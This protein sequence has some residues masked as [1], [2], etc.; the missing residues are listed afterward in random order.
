LAENYIG[1][2]ALT[3]G[4]IAYQDFFVRDQAH[5][6]SQIGRDCQAP[7]VMQARA[8][9]CGS[10]N[11]AF[12]KSQ[13]HRLFCDATALQTADCVWCQILDGASF[14]QRLVGTVFVYRFETACGNANTHK[15]LQFRHPNPLPSQVRRENARHTFCNMSPHAAFLFS[16]TAP[17]DDAPAHRFRTRYTA[18]S[19][20]DITLK[21]ARKLPR[22]GSSVK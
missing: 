15:L 14:S 12:E 22:I 2:E 7:F 16:K 6:L 9:N 4:Q 10:M 1:L 19:G 11:L 20:H 17:M 13:L 21:Q 18:N 5:Q 3:I 8:G